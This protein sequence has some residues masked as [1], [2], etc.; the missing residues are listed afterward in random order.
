MTRFNRKFSF[1]CFLFLLANILC[2]WCDNSFLCDSTFAQYAQRTPDT[3]RTP[4]RSENAPRR[5]TL[6]DNDDTVTSKSLNPQAN[7]FV[8]S[9]HKRFNEKPQF[10]QYIKPFL[11]VALI[12]GVTVAGAYLYNHISTMYAIKG[13]YNS[14]KRLFNELCQ[15]HEILPDERQFL[16]MFAEKNR[17]IDPLILFIEPIFFH[18]ARVNSEQSPYYNL[19]DNLLIKIFGLP[20]EAGQVGDGSSMVWHGQTSAEWNKN[21]GTFIFDGNK[22]GSFSG[23]ESAQTYEVDENSI[24]ETM[25]FPLGG[26]APV[27]STGEIAP[28]SSSR[29]KSAWRTSADYYWDDAKSVMAAGVSMVLKRLL[30]KSRNDSHSQSADV[31]FRAN[32]KGI[33]VKDLTTK[34]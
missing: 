30:P 5:I 9:F 25:F 13:G 16:R 11:M 27:S 21:G 31:E 8:E 1:I 15:L 22:S 33:N 19:L 12:V 4:N 34:K 26:T 3:P 32:H 24:D 6:E 10:R 29:N 7:R 14:P 23:G 18:Q 20:A 17:G 28:I 2:A